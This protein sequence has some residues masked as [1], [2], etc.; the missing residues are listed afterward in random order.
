M[1]KFLRLDIIIFSI[2]LLFSLIFRITNLDLIEFKTDEAVNLALASRPFFGHSFAPGGTVSSIGVLNPPLFN[3]ILTPLTFFTLDPK[4]FSFLIA[5]VNSISIALFYLVVKKYYGQIIAFTS[6]T[7]FA[8]SPWAIFFSRKIWTQDLLIPFFVLMFYSLHK[9]IEERKQ[10][11]WL[12]F[13]ISSLFLIQ[14]HEV[15][16]IFIILISLSLLFQKVK[17]NF[18]YIIIGVILGVLPLLPYFIYEIKNGYPDFKAV[19]SA[20]NRLSPQRSVDIFLRPLQITGQGNISFVLGSDLGTF[21][22]KFPLVDSFRKIFYFEYILVVLGVSIYIKKFKTFNFLGYSAILLP[23]VYF[24]L[25]IESF[26]HYYII[27]L[28]LL[29]LFLGTYF[30]FLIQKNKLLKTTSLILFMSLLISSLFFDISFFKLLKD[31]GYFQ[32][33]YGDSLKNSESHVKHKKYDE[34]F[35]FQF[36][37]LNY[38]FGYN[39]FAKMVYADTTPNKIPLLEKKLQ[40]SDDP[41]VKQELLAFYTKELPTLKTIDILR[42]KSKEIPQYSQI[43]KVA[44]EDYM[45]KNYKKDYVSDNFDFRFFYPEHWKASEDKEKLTLKGDYVYIEIVKKES[46]IVKNGNNSYQESLVKILG[47]DFK[48]IECRKKNGQ[49]CEAFYLGQSTILTISVLPLDFPKGKVEA[50][51]KTAEEIIINLRFNN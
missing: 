41:R 15:S 14:L 4:A 39:P 30:E 33:D 22:K 49:F 47:Q 46:K 51:F 44:L 24:L 8:F 17:L 42:K 32:G 6:S 31:Q 40:E 12:P 29:F 20:R 7:L 11:F 21:I 26:M 34:L 43:Y 13:T 38:A 2:I 16:I 23:F 3:Y 18:K 50:D 9:T 36:I 45:E 37:P 28:P 19:I 25:K 35:L 48:K 1:S 5:L 27:I 10:I